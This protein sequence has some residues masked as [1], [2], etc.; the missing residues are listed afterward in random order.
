MESEPWQK[1]TWIGEY[2]VD[3]MVFGYKVWLSR[4]GSYLAEDG[5]IGILMEDIPDLTG[6]ILAVSDI[7]LTHQ[8]G[9]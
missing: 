4:D 7:I 3:E 8:A 2:Y 5:G 6:K 1:D 9:W